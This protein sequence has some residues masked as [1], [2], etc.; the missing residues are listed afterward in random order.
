MSVKK[1]VL[2]VQ[3]FKNLKMKIETFGAH[4]KYITRKSRGVVQ[5]SGEF[6]FLKGLIERG[7]H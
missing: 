5:V 6:L 4:K 2:Y 1:K 7:E 3:E